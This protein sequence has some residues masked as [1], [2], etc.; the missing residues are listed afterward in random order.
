MALL[1]LTDVRVTLGDRPLLGGLSLSMGVGERVAIMGP[2]GVGK[3]T[4]LDVVIG[5]RRPNGGRVRVLGAGPPNPSV[6]FVPQDPGGSLLPWFSIRENVLLPLRARGGAARVGEDALEEVRGRLDPDH[7]VSLDA[8]PAQLSGGQRQRAALMRGAIGQP[9]LL[10]CDE[11]LSAIDAPARTR[12]VE[13][14]RSLCTADR[15]PGLLFVTHSL[16]TALALA[17]R[18]VILE[19]SPGRIKTDLA[20]DTPGIRERLS[21]LLA[22][23][24]C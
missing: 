21:A 20:S 17:T 8:R 16:A 9:Q 15:G 13:A 6:G 10:V 19:G 24:R 23:A 7:T 12:S 22:D 18:V 14:L 1:E 3:S 4:L 5:V 11:P 2:N